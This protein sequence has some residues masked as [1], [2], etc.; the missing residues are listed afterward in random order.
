[1][2]LHSPRSAAPTFFVVFDSRRRLCEL[3]LLVALMTLSRHEVEWMA[4][5]AERQRIARDLHDG[6][7]Q[8]LAVIAAYGDQLA[9]EL[10]H[11]HPLAIAARRALAALRGAIVDLS[12]SGAPTTGAALRQV[13]DELEDRFDV[14]VNVQIKP[15]QMQSGRDDLD[16]AQRE[17]VVRIAREA[18]VNAIRHGGAQRINVQLDARGPELLRVSDNGCGIGTNAIRSRTGLG[19]P[20]MRARAESIGARLVVR[21]RADGG[22]ELEV[23]VFDSA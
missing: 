21:R 19:L 18:I 13:A 20:T 8:D 10:G 15:N 11:E 5:S 4:I 14:K 23:R 16:H 22:T 2:R 17:E 3:L 12:A 7:A 6:L 9:S 1:M